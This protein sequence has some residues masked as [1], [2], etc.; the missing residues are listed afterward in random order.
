MA[1]TSHLRLSRRQFLQRT[2]LVGAATLGMT[3]LAG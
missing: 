1:Q 2:A 3:A